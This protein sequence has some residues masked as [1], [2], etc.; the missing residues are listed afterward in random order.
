MRAG[1]VGLRGKPRSDFKLDPRLIGFVA[2][3]LGFKKHKPA[4]SGM[5]LTFE[6]KL[7]FNNLL[8]TAMK[9]G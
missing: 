9:F 8:S 6:R 1:L 3:A 4:K 5:I 7:G 2:Q